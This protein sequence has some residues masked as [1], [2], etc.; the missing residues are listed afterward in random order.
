MKLFQNIQFPTLSLGSYSVD[1]RLS[2]FEPIWDSG[3]RKV[4]QG[5]A[6][7]WG[8]ELQ[9]RVGE[10]N[11]VVEEDIVT[12]NQELEDEILAKEG[13]KG[14]KWLKLENYR[15]L[16]YFFPW[17]KGE[18]AP[19]DPERI[20]DFDTVLGFLVL[21][22]SQEAKFRLILS[23]LHLLGY[24]QKTK[25]FSN[26]VNSEAVTKYFNTLERVPQDFQEVSVL[27][28]FIPS[29]KSKE[30]LAIFCHYI[31][32]QTYQKFKEPFRTKLMLM[33]LDFETEIIQV[34][35]NDKMMKKD[36]KK[37]IKSLLK[38]DKNNVELVAKFVEVECE[39]E[40]YEA[41]YKLLTTSLTAFNKNF[42]NQQDEDSIVSSLLLIRTGVEM[43]L[44]EICQLAKMCHEEESGE[45]TQ[46]QMTAHQD[47]L[48]WYLLQL[49][50]DNQFQPF[51]SKSKHLMIALVEHVT[52]FLSSWIYQNMERVNKIKFSTK[53]PTVKH[54]LVEVM[55]FYAWLLRFSSGWQEATLSLQKYSEEIGNK[56]K[57][58]KQARFNEECLTLKFIQE[59]IDKI[60]FDILWFESQFDIKVKQNLRNLY[61]ECLHSHPHSSYFHEKL[62][63]VEESVSVVSGV[64][65]EVISLVKDKRKVN[66]NLVKQVLFIG[67]KKFVKVLNPENL[68]ELPFVGL[69]FL[70]KLHNLLE[71]FVKLSAVQHNPLVWR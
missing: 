16:E 48:Q 25:T 1:D 8:V 60:A 45:A 35:N 43:E 20:V 47:K 4:G 10:D 55:F 38:E 27:K 2:L 7:G 37:L 19:E 21:F 61:I 5:G 51:A 67:L 26:I 58:Q 56:L 3:V 36:L 65:R 33:W 22:C 18:E 44:R 12:P 50:S 70:N 71:Y 46:M 28:R 49:G 11:L 9:E 14:D 68:A 15:D 34:N 69:G 31:F 29:Y 23:L 59:S 52:D 40:G 64:W 41:G 32:A 57:Y 24:E 66:N 53:A 62:E 42:L 6:R 13:E 54:S 30:S 17:R 63:T 39:L